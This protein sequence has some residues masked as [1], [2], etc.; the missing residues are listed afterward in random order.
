M[1]Y[2]YWKHMDLIGLPRICS[3]QPPSTKT[4]QGSC[5]FI[6]YILESSM[7]KQTLGGLTSASSRWNT[8]TSAAFRHGWWTFQGWWSRKK[9]RRPGKGEWWWIGFDD[10][11]VEVG[12]R[13]WGEG[14]WRC[15]RGTHLRGKGRWE[16]VLRVGWHHGG[17]VHGAHGWACG[18]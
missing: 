9:S 7:P 14:F 1:P 13:C 4:G 11:G 15:R 18:P 5:G 2:K 17:W 8:V 6:F 16:E 12:R 3:M 10:D